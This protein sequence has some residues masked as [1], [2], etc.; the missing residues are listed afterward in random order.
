MVTAACISGDIR[1]LFHHIGYWQASGDSHLWISL[2]ADTVPA[3][4]GLGPSCGPWML[5]CTDFRFLIV[6]QT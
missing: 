6:G 3:F 4:N 5:L 1:Y 2:Y